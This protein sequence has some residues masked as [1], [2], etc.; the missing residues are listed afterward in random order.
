MKASFFF[1]LLLFF[2]SV[3][4][5][6]TNSLSFIAPERQW[7]DGK[8]NV[9]NAT[10]KSVSRNGAV[11]WLQSATCKKPLQ[12][13]V[14][15]LSTNDQAFVHA[16]LSTCRKQHLVWDSG[17]YISHDEHLKRLEQKVLALD[18][19]RALRERARAAGNPTAGMDWRERQQ[20][21]QRQLNERFKQAQNEAL[22][23]KLARIRANPFMHSSA[24]RRVA[25]I[26]SK[27]TS[28]KDAPSMPVALDCSQP[29]KKWN[30]SKEDWLILREADRNFP[31]DRE[32][33]LQQN[34]SDPNFNSYEPP[35]ISF[36][37]DGH[38]LYDSNYQ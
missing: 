26:T 2:Y 5:A 24:E 35:R 22:E 32:L 27:T 23:R 8:G 38:L 11:I 19:Q 36:G 18:E 17:I 31:R 25:Q 37:V 9:L 33:Y 7:R 12:V 6:Q 16:Y 30:V 28:P 1:L 10:W 20:F 4:F 29:K 13:N 14:R 21:E 34:P 3:T 15:N